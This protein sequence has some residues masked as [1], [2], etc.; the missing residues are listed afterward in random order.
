MTTTTENK[1]M[2][3]RGMG[4]G[5]RALNRLAGSDLLDRIRI[6]KGV[7][8]ALFQGTKNGFKT[9]TAAAPRPIGR[10]S[11]RERVSSVV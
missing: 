8:K 3:E 9:A 7:E 4:Y 5:L 11:C 6:R 10:A 2:A 1:G